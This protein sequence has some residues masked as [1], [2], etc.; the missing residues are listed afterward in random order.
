MARHTGFTTMSSLLII[1]GEDPIGAQLAARLKRL[2]H[3]VAATL[4]AG[5]ERAEL[6]QALSHRGVEVYFCDPLDPLSLSPAIAGRDELYLCLKPEIKRPSERR[7]QLNAEGWRGGGRAL[8]ELYIS[9]R[10][11]QRPS[12]VPDLSYEPDEG[13]ALS[14]LSAAL[15]GSAM[16]SSVAPRVTLLCSLLGLEPLEGPLDLGPPFTPQRAPTALPPHLLSRGAQ[17][18]P[19]STVRARLIEQLKRLLLP[20]GARPTLCWRAAHL[21]LHEA[22]ALGLPVVIYGLPYSQERGLAQP[23]EALELTLMRR[24]Q[25]LS[26]ISPEEL[27]TALILLRAYALQGGD[28][29]GWWSFDSGELSAQELSEGLRLR[30]PLLGS[31]AAPEELGERSWTLCSQRALLSLGGAWRGSSSR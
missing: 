25:R 30:R 27:A 16:S 12:L 15:R 22:Q 24:P 6:A 2:G 9:L 23:D 13:R 4:S 5:E 17:S 20:S 14:P 29:S 10:G 31:Q 3:E 1:G 8:A 26:Y 28:S 19:P 11:E 7:A 18:P 21:A